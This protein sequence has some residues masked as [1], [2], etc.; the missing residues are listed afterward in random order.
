MLT[1]CEYHNLSLLLTAARPVEINMSHN[2]ELVMRVVAETLCLGELPGSV[3]CP[4]AS[5]VRCRTARAARQH[6]PES[7]RPLRHGAERCDP[8]VGGDLGDTA[9]RRHLA[10]GHA[11]AGG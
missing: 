1:V 3:L 6:R 9:G 5:A 11:A 2:N 8:A 10:Q 4:F 7:A